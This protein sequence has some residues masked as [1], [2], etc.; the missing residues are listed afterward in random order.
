MFD[1]EI[2]HDLD[3]VVEFVEDIGE[4]LAKPN[5]RAPAL[6]IA[7]EFRNQMRAGRLAPISSVTQQIRARRGRPGSVPLVETGRIMRSITVKDVRKTEVEIGSLLPQSAF[8]RK[9]GVTSG[10]SALPGKRV[11]GRDYL[12]VTTNLLNSVAKSVLDTL[13]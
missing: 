9:G 8:L 1:I 4:K 3:K 2:S 6:D 13:G 5:L 11:P 12:P 10:S 7:K